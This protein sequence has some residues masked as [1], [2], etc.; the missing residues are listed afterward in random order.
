M[1]EGDHSML[2]EMKRRSPGTLA[3]ICGADRRLHIL[4]ERLAAVLVPVGGGGWLLEAGSG[5][6]TRA[7]GALFETLEA[8]LEQIGRLDR[9]SPSA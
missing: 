4:G 2:N 8:A 1:S 5:R 7:G 6:L 9:P 3:A